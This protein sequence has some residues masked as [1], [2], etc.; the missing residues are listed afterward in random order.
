MPITGLAQSTEPQPSTNPNDPE[1][2][3]CKGISA[4]IS[5]IGTFYAARRLGISNG[6]AA[7]GGVAAANAVGE[8]AFDRACNSVMN[9]L[10]RDQRGAL[11]QRQRLLQDWMAQCDL[12]PCGIAPVIREGGISIN[13]FLLY[14]DHWASHREQWIVANTYGGGIG[15][16][17]EP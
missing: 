8:E 17:D 3:G 15:F 6:A 13:N 9:T 14:V 16:T 7:A 1:S 12:G 10:E 4:A 5:A 2:I 11:V